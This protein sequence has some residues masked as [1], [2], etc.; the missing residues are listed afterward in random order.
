[1][2]TVLAP[3]SGALSSQRLD[4]AG[5]DQGQQ[6]EDVEGPSSK[7]GSLDSGAGDDRKDRAAQKSSEAKNTNDV[8]GTA[9][10]GNPPKAQPRRTVLESSDD[11]DL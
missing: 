2:I 3:S 8:A 1:M 7:Q 10:P 5:S 6:P 9:E 4:C 11:D